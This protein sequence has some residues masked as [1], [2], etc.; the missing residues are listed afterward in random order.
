MGIT[1][2]LLHDAAKIKSQMRG[3]NRRPRS[4]GQHLRTS[5]VD[6]AQKSGFVELRQ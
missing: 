6:V 4:R 5:F 2:P 3:N 1:S